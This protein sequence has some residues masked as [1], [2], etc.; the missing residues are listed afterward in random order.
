MNPRRVHFRLSEVRKK[1]SK[2]GR[3]YPGLPYGQPPTAT[4]FDAKW[5]VHVATAAEH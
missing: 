3:R 2:S 5:S 1:I 4:R